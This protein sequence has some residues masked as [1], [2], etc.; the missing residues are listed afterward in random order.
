MF[1]LRSEIDI[2]SKGYGGGGGV[3]AEYR[4]LLVWAGAGEALLGIPG[5]GTGDLLFL[6]F[7]VLANM[8][9]V[10]GGMGMYLG[11]GVEEVFASFSIPID[12]EI[13]E[14]IPPP[15]SVFVASPHLH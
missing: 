4:L 1:L 2:E 11:L 8:P 12:A 14:L 13:S 5:G 6:P 15:A 7:C 9:L 3:R 10:L